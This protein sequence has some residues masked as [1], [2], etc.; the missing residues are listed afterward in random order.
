[1]TPSR[2]GARSVVCSVCVADVSRSV[3]C[4]HAALCSGC[5]LIELDYASQ[6][7]RKAELLRGALAPHAVFESPVPE[8]VVGADTVTGYRVRA[9]LVVASGPRLGLYARASHEVVDIPECRVLAPSLARTASAIRQLLADPPADAGPALVARGTGEGALAAVDLREALGPEGPRVLVG[10]VLSGPRAVTSA[11]EAAA[12]A[13]ILCAQPE[14]LGVG[15]SARPARGPRV[16]G[17]APR[18]VAGASEAV[19]TVGDVEHLARH[20]AFVQAHRG[21]ALRLHAEIAARLRGILG[22]LRGAPVLD[23]YGGSGAIALALAAEGARVTLIEAFP[24]AAEAARRAG[25]GGLEVVVGDASELA[26]SSEAPA[27]VVVNPPRRGLSPRVRA[28]VVALAPRA[29]AYVSCA[30]GTLARDLAAFRQLGFVAS[31]LVPFDMIPLSD[32]VETLALLVPGAEPEPVVLGEGPGYIA[33]DKPAHVP[34]TRQGEHATDLSS[35]VRRLAGWDRAVPLTRLDIGVSGVCVFARDGKSEHGTSALAT[36]EYL[37]LVRGVTKAKGVVNRPLTV[38]GRE[39]SART[40]YQRLAV[41]GGHSLLAAGPE[42]GRPHQLRRHLASI[43]HPVVGDERYGHAATNRHFADKYGLDRTFVH[44]SALS[45]PPADGAPGLLLRS[46][47]AGDLV[48]VR[49]RLE[50]R[51]AA[52]QSGFLLR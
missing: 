5:P 29:I 12:S 27:A 52:S 20:G 6:L 1:M 8:A 30:P 13:A 16:L 34:V 28:A 11:E 44:S 17:D 50:L 2:N 15:V 32:Q 41:V 7:E 22:D 4:P 33:V 37:V 26:R 42:P 35:R 49:A 31:A 9:K 38:A 46:E 23:V 51:S 25:R 40:R 47:L 36:A 3:E 21:Q 14:V 10:L 48:A 45:L 43:G 24:P 19:D 18:P 39:L